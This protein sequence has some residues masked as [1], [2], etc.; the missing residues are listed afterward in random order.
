MAKG[1]RFVLAALLLG[2]LVAP[3]GASAQATLRYAVP[4]ASIGRVV[5]VD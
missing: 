5:P 2:A 3:A 1:M 4:A